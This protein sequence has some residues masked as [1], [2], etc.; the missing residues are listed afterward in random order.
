MTKHR[1]AFI[2]FG[3]MAGWH[4]TNIK[5]RIPEIEIAGVYDVREDAREKAR[6]LG[7]K[8]YESREALLMDQTVDLVTVATPNDVHKAISIAALRAGKNVICEKPVTLN[9]Q[10]LSEIIAVSKETGKLFSVHQNRRWDK[11]F[12]I[13]KEAIATDLVGNPYFVESRVL[14][15]RAESMHGWRGHRLN[16]GG[17][18]LDWGVHLIDQALQLFP[19]KVVSVDAHLQQLFGDEVDDNIKILLRFEN[20]VSYLMEMATNCFID[21]PRWHV[22]G[23]GGTLMIKDWSCAGQIIKLKPGQEMGWADDIVYTEAGPTRTMAPRPPQTTQ[24][25]ALPQVKTDW[26]EY[27]QNILAVLDKGEELIVK[28]EEC[29]RVMRVIDAV[30]QAEAQGHGL[31]CEI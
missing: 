11:D 26:T 28:P 27:Y 24:T 25:V 12:R 18:V 1:L 19:C 23:T 9:A 3:G 31:K 14:G 17:M 8:A 7:L 10:E 30:F 13:V 29:L 16:G 2:G 22:S 4:Y 20:K 21:Q 6:Q 5:E 15:S